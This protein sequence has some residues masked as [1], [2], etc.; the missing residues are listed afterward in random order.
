M[1]AAAPL[2]ALAL[3]A[4]CG[5]DEQ[6]RRYAVVQRADVWQNI[7]LDR[8]RPRLARLRDAWDAAL[9]EARGDPAFATLGAV[10]DPDAAQPFGLP[11][12]GAYRCRTLHLGRH[13]EAPATV[14]PLQVADWRP[15]RIVEAGPLL[16]LEEGDGA[17]R[18]QALLY[19]DRDRMVVLGTVVL[20]GEGRGFVYGQDAMRDRAGV[21]TRFADDRWRIELP[22]P[23]WQSKLDLVE[24]APA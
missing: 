19:P 6:V 8:D 7:I 4:A 2:L 18:L 17:Q 14:P 1:R 22:W 13:V 23:R 24:I 12:A 11:A 10:I 20:A 3:L 9:A 16:R 15:C 5:G 21:L